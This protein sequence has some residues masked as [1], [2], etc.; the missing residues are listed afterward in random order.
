[1]AEAWG[2]GSV[3]GVMPL[4]DGR[5]YCYAA[6]PAEPGDRARGDGG[7]L[8]DLVRRFGGWHE[9]IPSLL[10]R[11]TPGDVLRHDVAE[12]AGPLSSFH[13]GRV[14]LL[15]DAAHPMTPNLGQGACQAL[16]DAVVLAR[17]LP[18]AAGSAG[19]GPSRAD[20]V[21]A[22]LAAYSAA[23]M[24]RT[25]YVVRWSRRAGAMTTWTS[26]VAVALRDGLAATM[27][28]LNPG[29]AL[30]GL[31]KIYDWQPP[32][33]AVDRESGDAIGLRTGPAGDR[34]GSRMA[35]RSRTPAP[36]DRRRGIHLLRGRQGESGLVRRPRR[37]L[38]VPFRI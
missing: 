2:R 5:V 19:G 12:L 1:M 16:E 32:A 9:P 22:A 7:E 35:G 38:A 36:A 20:S 6:A 8:A 18:A 13:Q 26:P 33:L 15:G 31:D 34:V 23:R 24:D 27:G 29:A 14:A 28:R 37:E 25:R 3:F 30:R 10:A 11:A 17:L 4:A 21:E